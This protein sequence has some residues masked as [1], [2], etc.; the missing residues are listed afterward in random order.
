MWWWAIFRHLPSL[1]SLSLAGLGAETLS[2]WELAGT[3]A[4]IPAEAAGRLQSFG[5]R[6]RIAV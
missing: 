6:R 3:A 5:G 4:K 1:Q 2:L